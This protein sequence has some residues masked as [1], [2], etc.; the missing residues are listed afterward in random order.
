MDQYF[1]IDALHNAFDRDAR[2]SSHP[3]V[4]EISKA[5]DVIEAFDSITYD[6]GGSV[7]RMVQFVMGEE[8]FRKGLT[9]YLNRFKYKNAEHRDLWNALNEAVPSSL[10]DWSGD[11]FDVNEFAKLWTRQM[12]YPVIEVKRLDEH[13]VELT[14][15]R[16]KLDEESLENPKF[17]NAK[18]WY[19]WGEIFILNRL[20]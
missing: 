15:R 3:L 2:A 8:N 9:I 1:Q 18:Y 19:K 5:E 10:K 4:F 6:K 14:Q 20:S 16:F 7:L 13:R 12:G 11:K 17:R